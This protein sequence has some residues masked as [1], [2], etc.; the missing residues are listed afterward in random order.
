MTLFL[1]VALI[2]KLQKVHPGV[3]YL[4]WLEYVI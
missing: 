4:G 2:V 1:A 3:G